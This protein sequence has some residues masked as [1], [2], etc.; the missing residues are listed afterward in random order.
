MRA[1]DILFAF[2][3]VDLMCLT[4]FL[5]V[6]VGPFKA[7]MVASVPVSIYLFIGLEIAKGDSPR[8]W[9]RL[10]NWLMA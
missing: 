4:A 1:V 9:K 10:F 5:W 8:L 3:V 2:F 7:V 6:A